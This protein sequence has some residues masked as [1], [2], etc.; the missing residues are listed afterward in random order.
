MLEVRANLMRTACQWTAFQQQETVKGLT[1]R[2]FGA[3]T[4]AVPGIDSHVTRPQRMRGNFGVAVQAR[5]FGC[6]AHQRGINS[7]RLLGAELAG[8]RHQRRFVLG[9]HKDAAGGRIN[10]VG[11]HEVIQAALFG[12]VGSAL[13]VAVEQLH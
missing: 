10:P 5:L 1:N 11:V 9:Q 12:P 7:D 8:Q 3:R 2:E 4:F 6:A 13:Q